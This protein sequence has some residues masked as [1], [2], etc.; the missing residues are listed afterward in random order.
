MEV[1]TSLLNTCGRKEVE[2]TQI[3]A[4]RR[5][6]ASMDANSSWGDGSHCTQHPHGYDL[7]TFS[8]APIANSYFCGEIFGGASRDRTDDLIV[9][10]DALSQLSYSPVQ[11][12]SIA[13]LF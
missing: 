10:N 8:G 12:G 3:V 5:M 9:A 13:Q 1:G 2:D 6:A 11:V 4:S 7:G